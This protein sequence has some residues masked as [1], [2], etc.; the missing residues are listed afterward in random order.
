[1]LGRAGI[2]NLPVTSLSAPP[3]V[4][5]WSSGP[6]VSACVP[7]PTSAHAQRDPRP[8]W[9]GSVGVC[10]GGRLE[11]FWSHPPDR[12]KAGFPPA[13]LAPRAGHTSP[14][15]QGAAGI[16]HCRGSCTPELPPLQAPS[17]LRPH[18]RVL[19]GPCGAPAG[20]WAPKPSISAP[21]WKNLQWIVFGIPFR[22]LTG[23][24]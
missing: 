12:V 4:R 1:M 23:R 17:L 5:P 22:Q 3:A 9:L 20:L 13:S 18:L 2:E 16:P 11:G 15:C 21:C 8:P 10:A 6:A 14:S 24:K 7:P 19:L